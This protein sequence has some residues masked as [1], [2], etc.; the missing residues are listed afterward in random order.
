MYSCIF[1]GWLCGE[2]LNDIYIGATANIQVYI[3]TSSEHI[4]QL[5]DD[6]FC[7]IFADSFENVSKLVIKQTN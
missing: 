4:Y 5:V 1:N 3:L 7:I 6:T 2:L